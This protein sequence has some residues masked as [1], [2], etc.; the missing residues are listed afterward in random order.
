MGKSQEE[1]AKAIA[2]KVFSYGKDFETFKKFKGA[3]VLILAFAQVTPE[4]TKESC[5]HPHARKLIELRDE[6]FPHL[7]LGIRNKALRAVVNFGILAANDGY[8]NI[9]DWWLR[10]I[11]DMVNKGE[12]ELTDITHHS[13][14][15]E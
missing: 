4:P 5:L 12:W 6:F 3:L 7:R 2:K 13:W 11:V 8:G 1:S 10:R 15:K 14:W 9:A